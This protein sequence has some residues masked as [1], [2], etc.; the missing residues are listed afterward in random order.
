MKRRRGQP[1]GKTGQIAAAVLSVLSAILNGIRE[2]HLQLKG[3]TF[4]PGPVPSLPYS[5]RSY[6]LIDSL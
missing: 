2:A 6:G 4:T 1:R 3:P 5:I